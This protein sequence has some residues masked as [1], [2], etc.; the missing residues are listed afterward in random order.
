[1]KDFLQ[2]AL[3]SFIGTLAALTLTLTLGAS[4]LIL[5]LLLL[6]HQSDPVVKDQSVLVMDLSLPIQ[7]T[8]PIPSLT[9]ALSSERQTVMAL[10]PLVENLKKAAKDDRIVALLL[11]ARRGA[12]PLTG[13][14]TLAEVRQ[15]IQVF[16]DSGKKVVAYGVNWN[17]RGYGLAVMADQIW[18]NPLGTVEINGFGLQPLFLSGALEKYGIGVQSVR[19][20]NYKSAI[21]PFTR[22]DLSPESRQQTQA[23]LT[24]LWSAYLQNLA[25]N[26]PLQTQTLQALADQQGFLL[27]KAAQG[28]GLVDKI[29]YWDQGLE[30]LVALGAKV[31]PDGEQALRQVSMATYGDVS[32]PVLP[33]QTS[34]N[35]I[36][37]LY[38]KGTI[39]DGKGGLDTVGSERF[40]PLLRQLQGDPAV[41]AVVLRIDSP[42]G[43]ATASDNLLREIQQL[44]RKKPVVVSMGDVAASGGY[45]IATGGERIF[46]QA[47]TVTGS[48][49]VFSLFFNVEKL[50]NTLGLTWDELQTAQLANLGSGITPKS[51]AELAVYQ[52]AVNQV[53]E[54]FLDKVAQSRG[55]PKAQVAEI[56]QGRVWSGTQAKQVGLVDEIGGLEQAIA[57]AA[58]RANLGQDWQVQEFPAPKD[59]TLV[60][61]ERLSQTQAWQALLP[62]DTRAQ[63]WEQ[64]TTELQALQT[65][66][67]ARGL[68]ARLPLF[69]QSWD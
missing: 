45:W 5:L 26:R 59:L 42:G 24:E 22:K 55:L 60:L 25:K 18:I 3:A 61:L 12:S 64:L 43:S 49:G 2:R 8:E 4:G 17:E 11:D 63:P 56:A 16:K 51:E 15:A 52:T 44:R 66:N 46:A 31:E 9:A 40:I 36:A 30:A 41:K 68:Y 62:S 6:S 20:G 47:S 48:I 53:Y 1:M 38:L 39:V 23:L 7:D 33:L 58:Q 13:Y 21:E 19:V 50:G 54:S 37:V 14:A 10:R 28:Q 69:W 35:T 29:G 27:A 32:V 57:H 34:D 65:F 67:D